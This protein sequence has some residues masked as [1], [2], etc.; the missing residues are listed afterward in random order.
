MTKPLPEH[1][2][3]HEAATVLRLSTR[4]VD[5]LAETGKLRKVKL[6]ANR[7][8][9]ERADLD[10]YLQ[11]LGNAGDG[12]VSPVEALTIKLA[13]DSAADTDRAAKI[14]DELLNERFP[15]CLVRVT[16][17]DIQIVW[18]AALGYTAQQISESLKR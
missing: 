3:R 6:S 15:G 16:D 9:F 4:Q 11:S 10:R 17:G 14:L 1:V 5:R 18:N 12:Y 2:T 13:L 7:S 8:G